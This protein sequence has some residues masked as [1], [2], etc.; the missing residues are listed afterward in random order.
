MSEKQL[1]LE[2]AINQ[3]GGGAGAPSPDL[4]LEQLRAADL[5]NAELVGILHGLRQENDT[6]RGLLH[7]LLKLAEKRGT[8]AVG[9]PGG[10]HVKVDHQQPVTATTTTLSKD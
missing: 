7:A 3:K 2:D 10:G 9:E 8:G 5:K 6:L 1:E 4:L